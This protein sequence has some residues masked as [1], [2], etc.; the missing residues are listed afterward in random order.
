[1]LNLRRQIDCMGNVGFN[2][3]E[4]TGGEQKWGVAAGEIVIGPE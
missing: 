4:A 2:V 3:Q 1:M